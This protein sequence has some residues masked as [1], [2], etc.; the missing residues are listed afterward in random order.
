M[1]KVSSAAMRRLAAMVDLVEPPEGVALRLG[2]S[3]GH[4]ELRPTRIVES[5][6]ELKY[7]DR[8]LLVISP[9]IKSRLDGCRLELRPTTAGD[10]LMLLQPE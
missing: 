4:F 1:F 2:R 5:D 8:L 3:N 9:E 10:E 6:F 7:K